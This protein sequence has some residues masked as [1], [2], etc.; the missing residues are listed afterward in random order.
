M[1]TRPVTATVTYP[2]GTLAT[3]VVCV[4][5]LVG[6]PYSATDVIPPRSVSV[7]THA[8]L[9]TFSQSLYYPAVYRFSITG[10]PQAT[11]TITLPSGTTPI[12]LASLLASGVSTVTAD[13]VQIAINATLAAFDLDDLADV[14]ALA[15]A[16]NDTLAFDG[17][18]WIARAAT[19]GGVS[20]H[21][22]LTGLDFASAGHTGFASSASV[23]SQVN[24]LQTD[25]NSRALS[26][27]LTTETSARTAALLTKENALG[28]PDTDGKILSGTVA[29][30]RLWI[31]AP[32]G[33][34]AALTWVSLTS[35]LVNSGGTTW[36]AE[37][38]TFA[39]I[40]YAIDG[41]FVH[42]R[43]AVARTAGSGSIIF[44]ALPVGIRPTYR[45]FVATAS[46]AGYAQ[47]N[48]LPAGDV[49]LWVGGVSAL[50]LT[51]GWWL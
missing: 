37:G 10:Y 48:I 25:I 9:G 12:T 18:R 39:P 2:D 20:A 47:L 8:T 24:T 44:A 36:Q 28:N 19:G 30:A 17:T 29:G 35:Y 49:Q 33:G 11:R 32:S 15:P 40:E 5:D 7:T 43:G 16:T 1:N 31:A 21:N 38:G 23:T 41:T 6:T 42:I 4:F 45:Q 27:A 34:A 3:G 14:S 13:V 22:A 46:A 51:Y 50:Q 26:S